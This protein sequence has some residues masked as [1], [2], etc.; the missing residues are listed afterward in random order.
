MFERFT[1]MAR[2]C[3]TAAQEEAQTLGHPG[4][5]PAHIFL[6][7]YR[8]RPNMAMTLLRAQDIDAEAVSVRIMQ[9][10]GRGGPSFLGFTPLTDRAK[11]VL[12]FALREALS[13]G[14]NHIGTEHLLLGLIREESDPAAQVL[15]EFGAD[16]VLMRASIPALRAA[17]AN[18]EG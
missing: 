8:V 1:A 6:S 15:A 17:P 10:I 7:L 2:Q 12:E 11:K 3:V 16:P 13:L 18:D 9:T 4:M 5:G 14:H